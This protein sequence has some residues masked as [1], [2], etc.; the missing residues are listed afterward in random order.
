LEPNSD[1]RA[2]DASP[3]HAEITGTWPEVAQ[4]TPPT[5]T[6]AEIWA[7]MMASETHEDMADV[8]LKLA[9]SGEREKILTLFA[10]IE[11]AKDA[12]DRDT[13]SRSL[14]ALHNPEFGPDLLEFLTRNVKDV[15]IADQTRD[16][17]ARNIAPAD[18]A[19][20]VEAIPEDSDEKED[21]LLRSYLVQTIARINSFEA[22]DA[23]AELC[24]NTPHKDV[25]TAAAQALGAIGT[26]EAVNALIAL[27][28]HLELQDLDNPIAQSLMNSANKDA[29]LLLQHEFIN[30]TNPVIRH[31]TAH[32]LTLLKNQETASDNPDP[33]A[34][35]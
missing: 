28:E 20:L 12:A 19:L 33:G 34:N 14:Q 32:A 5:E 31:A 16:A 4:P 22:V 7:R 6:P 3:A 21:V 30:S 17:L 2:P 18:I 29:R 35:P 9:Q 1:A 26:P 15:M 8:A 10:A 13:L 27:I 23:L 24:A 11:S 25:H